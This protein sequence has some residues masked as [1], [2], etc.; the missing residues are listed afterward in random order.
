MARG[1]RWL[2]CTAAFDSASAVATARSAR[3]S[4]ERPTSPTAS[5]IRS[6]VGAMADRRLGMRNRVRIGPLL[7]ARR[8]S[9]ATRE[10]LFWLGIKERTL[11]ILTGTGPLSIPAGL[12]PASVLLSAS[13]SGIY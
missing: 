5:R 12:L 1:F 7:R 8:R 3:R 10:P 13:L 4:A 9:R 11:L 6:T 2:P